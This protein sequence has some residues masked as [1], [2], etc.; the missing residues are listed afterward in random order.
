[1]ETQIEF[2]KG[3]EIVE[4]IGTG[5]FGEVYK[6]YQP[7]LNREVAI[8]QILPEFANQADFIRNFEAEAQRV[9]RLEHP[10]IIPLYDFWRDPH[11][12]YLVMRWLPQTL[13]ARL[14]QGSLSLPD[15]LQL[16]KQLG[17]ALDLTHQHGVIHRDLKP[18]NILIDEVGNYYLADFG[19]AK[20]LLYHEDVTAS[21]MFKGSLA[22][23]APEQAKGETISPQTDIYSFGVMLYEVLTGSH[24]F[25]G[26]SSAQMLAKHL[27]DPLPDLPPELNYPEDV[28][29]VLQ[30][31]TAKH[32]VDR[33]GNINAFVEAFGLAVG[34]RPSPESRY[35]STV[36]TVPDEPTYTPQGIPIRLRNPYKGLY[37]F[38]RIDTDDFFGRSALVEHM[39]A[40]FEEDHPYRNLLAVVGPSGS[41]KSS[42]VKAGLVPCLANNKSITNQ[43]WLVAEMT[44]AEKPLVELRNALTKIATRAT[45]HIFE[46]LKSDKRGLVWAVASILSENA[47]LILVVDQFEELFTT[48]T[49]KDDIVQFLDILRGAVEDGTGCVRVILTLR[50]DFM[51]RPLQYID[52]GEMLKQRVEYVLPMSGDEIQQ[53]ITQPAYQ[54]GATVESELV[55]SIISDIQDEP[56]ALPLLQYTLTELF[57][58]REGLHLTLAKYHELGGVL[59]ALAQR[60]EN[61]F[62]TLTHE[63]QSITRQVFLRLV[64]LGEGVE[65]TRRRIKQSEL[66]ATVEDTAVLQNVLD[67][68]SN[69]RLLTFDH[70]PQTREPTVEVAHEALIREWQRLQN[71]LDDSR[72]DIR[73][74]RTL[75]AATKEWLNAQLNPDFLLRGSRLTQFATWAEE[76]PLALT[77]DERQFLNLSVKLN[78]QRKNRLR[79][80]RIG[81]FAAVLAVA[82]IMTFLAIDSGKQRNTAEN[83]LV[84]A[85]EARNDAEQEANERQSAVLAIS[86]KEALQ[87]Y[88]T[89]LAIALAFE[90]YAIPDAPAEASEAITQAGYAPGTRMVL[91]GH[92]GPVSAAVYSPDGQYILSGGGRR[93]GLDIRGVYQHFPEDSGDYNLRLWDAKTGEGIREFVG[94]TGGVWDI[95]FSSDGR[96]AVSGSSDETVIVWDVATGQILYRFD[97]HDVSQDFEDVYSVAISPDGK[98]VLSGDSRQVIWWD[99][100]TGEILRSFVIEDTHTNTDVGSIAW[101]LKFSPDGS[102]TIVGYGQRGYTVHGAIVKWNL[103]SDSTDPEW[104]IDARSNVHN[105]DISA[106]GQY[107]LTSGYTALV[108]DY[109][110]RVDESYA[111][112]WDMETGEELQMFIHGFY[113]IFGAEISPNGR[114]VVTAGADHHI[115]IWDVVTGNRL[116]NLRGHEDYVTGV[117]FSPD[118]KHLVSN[119]EDSTIRLWDIYNGAQ[120]WNI[121][122]PYRIRYVDVSDNGQFIAA[123]T[124][125]EIII[126]DTESGQEIRRLIGHNSVVRHC[127][128]MP[129]GQTLI[130]TASDS[131][132]RLWDIETGEELKRFVRDTNGVWAFEIGPNPRYVLIAEAPPG[133]T[134]LPTNYT[135]KLR[136]FETDTLVRELVGNRGITGSVAYSPDGLYALTAAE[137]Q[138]LRLWNLTTGAEVRHYIAD[139]SNISHVV[140]HPSENLAL[141]TWEDTRI[142]LWDVD[143]FEPIQFYD[144]HSMRIR[145]IV[146]SA[147]GR[148]FA[149]TA[150][151]RVVIVWNTETG[152]QLRKFHLLERGGAFRVDF[153]PDNQY[154]VSGGYQGSVILWNIHD[155]PAQVIDYAQNNRYIRELDCSERETYQIEPQCGE[156]SAMPTRTPYPTL[157]PT[158]EGLAVEASATS[159]EATLVTYPTHTPTI[160]LTMLPSPT[161]FVR[162]ELILGQTHRANIVCS[163]SNQ[164]CIEDYW[165]FDSVGEQT[166]LINFNQFG[167]KISVFA[168]DGTLVFET[169]DSSTQSVNFEQA[170]TYQF[171]VISDTR[172]GASY[173]L[174]IREE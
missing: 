49:N 40:R 124:H 53:A 101:D 122:Y 112:L 84:V 116:L 85:E 131:T 36:T 128:F 137:D 46:Q 72:H 5:G 47:K 45:S 66:M 77:R 109:G 20:D 134:T 123:A 69:A 98:T 106:D 152:T 60:A 14:Q 150:E 54:V 107:L 126:L 31:A 56:G 170:G 64:T 135:V 138:S 154:L 62:V 19:I 83:A 149:S 108:E 94:H 153:T 38:E 121:T 70:D 25:A 13:Y 74:E 145:D 157:T 9:A 43:Q 3:Y 37:A 161:P 110:L 127:E 7:I 34:D 33:F 35:I 67:I 104:V 125:H 73:Q 159:Q 12:A 27:N 155:S 76:T 24:P 42:L 71:W 63:Q 140:Y 91:R 95:A 81:T 8:K 174:G 129:D 78:Q 151:D 30:T 1:M 39:L 167:L 139:N 90:A 119:S 18:K 44:P 141:S 50:A 148:Y 146:F 58:E 22:Y 4:K 15:C 117:S 2:I 115:V 80:I 55:A 87:N 11:G 51:D 163:Q 144:G 142:V 102:S 28:N 165:M 162:G 118:G 59:G 48:S 160:T 10:H 26:L 147:D 65:D 158:P 75:A 92:T 23:I 17:A 6:A 68:F 61:L 132:V 29:L 97:G 169:T 172:R 166:L 93:V 82:A 136:D 156:A 52:F 96:L 57:N 99:I 164:G 171:V 100:E 79:L 16:V 173:T 32:T 103:T 86:A 21:H 133:T 113:P 114:Y 105:I 120:T 130:S 111:K 41:G 89:D 143:T 168:P 88:N